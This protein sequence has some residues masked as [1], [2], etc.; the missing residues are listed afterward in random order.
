M[1]ILYLFIGS[2]QQYVKEIAD[3]DRYR[4]DHRPQCEARRPLTA[5]GFYSRTLVDAGFDGHNRRPGRCDY[6]VND[7]SHLH[8]F[9]D[10][11]FDFIYSIITLQHMPLASPSVIWRSSSAY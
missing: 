1:Q 9:S 6:L 11:Q 3:P 4:P 2:V 8:R 5:H 7:T 10:G